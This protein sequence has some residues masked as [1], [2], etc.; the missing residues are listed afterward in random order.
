MSKNY[1]SPS[2][3]NNNNNNISGSPTS[4]HHSIGSIN[5]LRDEKDEKQKLEKTNFD[6]KMK[7]FYLEENMRKNSNDHAISNIDGNNQNLLIIEDLNIKLEERNIL[8][9]KAKNAMESLSN[10]GNNLFYL[11]P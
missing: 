1:S 10:E 2:N 5:T 4:L 11:F 8:L 3:N 6:L 7:L 9:T